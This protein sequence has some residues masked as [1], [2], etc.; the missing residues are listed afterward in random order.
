MTHLEPV[1]EN[2]G[3][4]PGED[5]SL[6]RRKILA[7][8][9]A[10]LA[11][12][13]AAVV[14][15]TPAAAVPT[16]VPAPG[17]P[18]TVI[19]ASGTAQV[20]DCR[21]GVVAYDVTETASC[22][23]G[24]TGAVDGVECLISLTRW[25]DGLSTPTFPSDLLWANGLPP[26]FASKAGRCDIVMFRSTDGGKHW[27]AMP[28]LTNAASS[29]APP[30]PPP[31]QV[32]GP[33]T[34]LAANPG[35]SVVTLTWGPP[36]GG[37]TV[38]SYN[39]YRGTTAGQETQLATAGNATSYSDTSVT[40]GVTYYYRVTAVNSTG[41]GTPSNEVSA[42]PTAAPPPTSRSLSL[43]GTSGSYATTPDTPSNRIS[44]D[45]D[46]RSKLRLAAS[47]PAAVGAIIGKWGSDASQQQYLMF[48]DTNGRVNAATRI[49][50]QFVMGTSSVPLGAAA[51]SP[52]WVRATIQPNTPSGGWTMRFYT[53]PDNG[54]SPGPWSALGNDVVSTSGG[55][56]MLASGGIDVEVGSTSGGTINNLKGNVYRVEILNGVD[57]PA[58]IDCDFTA[59]AAGSRTFTGQ[60]GETWT[61]K[62]SAAIQ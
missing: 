24:V 40:N 29:T 23:Y 52:M 55:G 43:P 39:V 51:T 32:P 22:S 26:F 30:P 9:A 14:K 31:P 8:S 42:T 46:L 58:V 25:S 16:P 56:A 36:S 59:P 45:I 15:A 41:E 1:S 57:G 2:G 61:V 13:L 20:L 62:G 21:G 6:S 28:A 11:A 27:Q 37:G 34:G 60:T 12:A 53:A 49:N 19:P 18:V 50:Q 47:P 38:T 48:V 17:V 7:G 33:P 54:N 5:G 4:D 3:V 44:S 10:G 35:D